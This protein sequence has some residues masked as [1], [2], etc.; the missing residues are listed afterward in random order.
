MIEYFITRT[1]SLE[2]N[3]LLINKENIFFDSQVEN[4]LALIYYVGDQRVLHWKKN[5]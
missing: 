3:N 2:N 4:T 1:T 5:I